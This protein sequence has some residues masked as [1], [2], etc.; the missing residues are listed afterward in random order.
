V[1]KQTFL[2]EIKIEIK[3]KKRGGGV[4]AVEGENNYKIKLGE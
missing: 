1:A 4:V 2:Q 3:F